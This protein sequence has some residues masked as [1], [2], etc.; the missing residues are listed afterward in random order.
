MEIYPLTVLE[1]GKPETEVHEGSVS[2]DD[3]LPNLQRLP[4]HCAKK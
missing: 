3:V 1:T 2:G 4:F